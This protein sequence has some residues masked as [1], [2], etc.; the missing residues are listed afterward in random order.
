MPIESPK[1]TFL[2]SPHRLFH[3]KVATTDAFRAACDY[4]MLQLMNELRSTVTVGLPTDP[5]VGMD[6]NSQL[7][8]A[9]RIIEILKTIHEP[10]P[11]PPKETRKTPYSSR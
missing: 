7:C 5:Y 1:Q 10:M 4:S 8:G 3:E 2:L 6:A 11:T 9:K